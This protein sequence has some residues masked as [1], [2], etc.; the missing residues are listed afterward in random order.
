ML[1]KLE[2]INSINDIEHSLSVDITNYILNININIYVF[3]YIYIYIY[4]ER[5]REREK[6]RGYYIDN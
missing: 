2:Y 6:Q 5:E 3:I 1:S 4:I